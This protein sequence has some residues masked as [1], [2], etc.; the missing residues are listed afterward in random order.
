L[1]KE[2]KGMKI[3]VLVLRI[4]LGMIFVILGANGLH[5]FLPQQSLPPGLA[6]QYLTALGQSHYALVPFAVQ[7]VG[8]ILLLVG[9]F[10]PLALAILAPVIVNI[11]CFH[12]FLFRTGL[13]MAIFVTIFWFILFFDYRRSFAGIFQTRP[14]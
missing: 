6:N 10:V 3:L 2:G 14:L 9:R 1:L 8:G 12:I 13:P 5:Q 7:F 4:L 11:L